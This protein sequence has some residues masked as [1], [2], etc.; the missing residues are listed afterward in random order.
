MRQH[1]IFLY[2]SHS[3]P[4][5]HSSQRLMLRDVTALPLPFARL[6]RAIAPSA[7]ER[8]LYHARSTETFCAS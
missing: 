1:S 3:F 6:C 8:H 7:H 4:F 5:S 2:V